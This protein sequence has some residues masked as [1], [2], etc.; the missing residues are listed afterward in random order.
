MPP[1]IKPLR[2]CLLHFYFNIAYVPEIKLNTAD[3]FSRHPLDNQP[4][5][6]DSFDVIEHYA[7]T[8]TDALSLIDMTSKNENSNDC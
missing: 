4:V 1:R 7:S 8:A 3:T 5:L 6:I 2:I